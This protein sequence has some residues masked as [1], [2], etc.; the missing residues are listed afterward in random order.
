MAGMGKRMG[1]HGERRMGRQL[2]ACPYVDL[3]ILGCG[4]R[5]MVTV[6][7]QFFC[8]PIAGMGELFNDPVS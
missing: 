7:M 8:L 6:F 3:G 4:G 2:S 1:R 5:L